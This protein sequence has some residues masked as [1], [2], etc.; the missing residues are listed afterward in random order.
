MGH[1]ED[2]VGPVAVGRALVAV[3]DA[4]E[5][6]HPLAGVED[7]VLG[8]RPHAH[9]VGREAGATVVEDRRDAAQAA[10]LAQ[11]REALE[12]G[13]LRDAEPLRRGREGLGTHRHRAL[14][15]ADRRDVLVASASIG[16]SSI[17]SI[18]SPAVLSAS[19]PP[20]ISRSMRILKSLSVGSWR[21]DSAPVLAAMT[22]S[23][24]SRPSASRA[25]RRS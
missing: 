9:A 13:L 8:H 21:I 12:H 1:R 6:G 3:R 25:R 18:A 19:V 2:G 23:V 16:S 14:G 20:S 11:R 10:A 17:G 24:P 5:R 15:R 22:S 4:A 7:L